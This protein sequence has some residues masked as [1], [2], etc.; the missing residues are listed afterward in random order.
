MLHA[1]GEKPLAARLEVL[2]DGGLYLE[3]SR[4][5]DAGPFAE[6]RARH[7]EAPV[8]RLEGGLLL[9]GFVDAHVHYPQTRVIGALGLDLLDWLERVTLL[10]EARFADAAHARRE[11]RTFLRALVG[12][13]AT[14]ALVFGSHFAPAQAALFEEAAALGFPLTSGLATGDRN[15]RAEL[16]TTPERAYEENRALIERFHGKNGL[17]YAVT[18]RFALAAS[19]AI[20]EVSSALLRTY[21]DL[22]FQTHLN[23]N[24]REIAAVARLFPAARDYLDVYDRFGLVGPRA[25]FAHD[26]HPNPR[27]LA[28][29]AAAAAWVAHCPSSNAFLGSGLFPMRAHLEAGVRFALGSDVGAGTRF[30]LLGEAMDAYKTQRQRKGGVNLSAAALLWLATRA[31]A[32]ALG[33]ADE[34]GGLDPGMS[35]DLVWLRPAPGSTLAAVLAH[36]E[37]PEHALG[38]AFALARE[39]AVAAVWIRGRL[40][41]ERGMLQAE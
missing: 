13:G 29:L 35:A 2:G 31:G 8:R 23:E 20:L 37:G 9:P 40:V 18:P 41:F 7:P 36:A 19:E 26:V 30:S 28:R 3:G 6:V 24:P 17:R 12:G 34:A 1:V 38:A 39:D 16:H 27:E 21:G 10:A 11:A 22:H 15:L 33:Q 4:I 14:R 32:A 5:A 25:V